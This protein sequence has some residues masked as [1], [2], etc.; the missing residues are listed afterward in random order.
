M[1]PHIFDHINRMRPFP[2][3]TLISKGN[4]LLS[5]YSKRLISLTVITLRSFHC[6]NSKKRL[7]EQIISVSKQVR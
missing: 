2:C 4:L 1:G 3:S 7:N 6:V 5:D